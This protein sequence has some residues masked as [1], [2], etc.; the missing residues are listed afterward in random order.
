[1]AATSTIDSELIFL[2]NKWGAA[3]DP[4]HQNTIPQGDG[5]WSGANSQNVIAPAYPVGTVI[6]CYND[7][8]SAGQSGYYEMIYLRAEEAILGA[9]SICVP[10]ATD[11]H[12]SV[13]DDISSALD[14][15]NAQIGVAIAAMTA[16]YY[17]WF[18]CGGVCPEAIESD[19]GGNY[20][21]DGSLAIGPMHALD[22]GDASLIGFT[23]SA[24]EACG[25][26]FAA[27]AA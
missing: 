1:M 17:G 13:T 5:T 21:A 4:N 19:M 23:V 20:N 15:T 18:W 14:A 27:D 22:A 7:G 16:Q 26:S 24:V 9:K 2:M 6:Q 25:M 8:D 12:Y 10:A 11:D 3:P